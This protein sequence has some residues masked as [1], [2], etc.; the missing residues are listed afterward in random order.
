MRQQAGAV[1][2]ALSDRTVS[3]REAVRLPLRVVGQPRLQAEGRLP[4]QV[5]AGRPQ[6]LVQVLAL[7]RLL[8]AGELQLRVAGPRRQ[9]E[10]VAQ[11]LPVAGPLP[12]PAVV[13][14]RRPVAVHPHQRAAA[15]PQRPAPTE[16]TTL[17]GAPRAS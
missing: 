2:W 15:A 10:A 5:V 13:L 16:L 11:R 1:A 9:Q 14:P 3:E 6:R 4:R 12:L 8:V 17:S 7:R